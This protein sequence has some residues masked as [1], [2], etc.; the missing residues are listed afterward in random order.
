MDA[1]P[2]VDMRKVKY[3][4]TMSLPHLR[5][6]AA[7]RPKPEQ[8][9]L[10]RPDTYQDQDGI[11][12]RITALVQS[13]R[14]HRAQGRLRPHAYW[15]QQGVDRLRCGCGDTRTPATPVSSDDDDGASAASNPFASPLSGGYHPAGKV[16]ANLPAPALS[17]DQRAGR[18]SQGA[19]ALGVEVGRSRARIGRPI[20]ADGHRPPLQTDRRTAIDGYHRPGSDTFFLVPKLH[21]GTPLDPSRNSISR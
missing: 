11:E 7:G 6:Q 15:Q 13:Q 1:D 5:H 17:R 16:S 3:W 10:Y 18:Q 20:R 14:A 8:L 21:L 12:R 2:S 4:I 9:Y 19:R